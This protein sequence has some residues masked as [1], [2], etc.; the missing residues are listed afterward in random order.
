MKHPLF[1]TV[2][3][4]K[5]YGSAVNGV[6]DTDFKGICLPHIDEIIGMRRFEQDEFSNGKTG[7]DKIEARFSISE[8]SWKSAT[9]VTLL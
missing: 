5:L 6:S 4:S 9:R 2:V 3:G 1:V 7:P 8:S